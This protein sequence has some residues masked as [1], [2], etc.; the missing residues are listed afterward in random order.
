MSTECVVPITPL[1]APF[2]GEG[3]RLLDR[4][5]LQNDLVETLD[6]TEH[7][8]HLVPK[9]ARCHRTFRHWRCEHNHDWAEA[10][11]SCSSRVCP[12]CSRHRSLVLGARVEKFLK[13]RT[14]GLRYAVL[15]EANC[16]DLAMG[17]LSLWQAWTRLRRWVEWKRMVKGCLVVLEVTRNRDDGTWHPHL[18]VLM[19]GE[20]IPVEQLRQMWV[21][22]TRGQGQIVHIQ[23][24]DAGT[25]REL[26]KYVTKLSDLLGDPASLDEFL[27]AIKGQRLMRTYG[28]FFALKVDDEDKPETGSCPDCGPEVHCS[29]VSLGPIPAWQLS[30][31]FEGVLRVSRDKNASDAR[32]KEALQFP[33]SFEAASR[34]KPPSSLIRHWDHL[35]D[36]FAASRRTSVAATSRTQGAVEW[37]QPQ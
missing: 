1:V 15:S 27:T 28:T 23:A 12:H 31:D 35:H 5:E 26:I 3:F 29:V 25:V 7:H 9:I 2:L 37:Q 13:G 33:P 36:K 34:G 4:Y 21:K 19:D 18:N 16:T 22:A 32:L 24:A 11:N 14:D 8:R 30:L 10:E 17:I 6:K 20:Y